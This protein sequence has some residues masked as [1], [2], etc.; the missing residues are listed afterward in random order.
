[1]LL[2]IINI[3]MCYYNNGQN[4]IQLCL[5]T[6]CTYGVNHKHIDI[7]CQSL[8]YYQESWYVVVSRY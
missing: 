3:I 2:Y 8:L 4:T 5:Q 1:M 7:S 6:L